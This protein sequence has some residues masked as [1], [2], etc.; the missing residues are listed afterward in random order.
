MDYI[1]SAEI[2]PDYQTTM[3]SQYNLLTFFGKLKEAAIN[4]CKFDMARTMAV[5]VE[6]PDESQGL[7]SLYCISAF[8][9]HP[10]VGGKLGA[11]LDTGAIAPASHHAENL[12]Y[13][14][15]SHTG[16][17]HQT[18]SWGRI[19]R[20]K[21]GGSSAACCGKLA[22]VME[23]YLKEYEYAKTNIKVFKKDGEVFLK[24]PHRFLGTQ[25]FVEHS[26]VR[27][28][29]NSSLI[30]TKGDV[31]TEGI[32]MTE[33]PHL[34][35]FKIH[36]DLLCA[37]RAKNKD[38]TD[39]PTPIGDDLTGDYFKFQWVSPDPVPDDITGRL[40]PLMH[41]IV[42][43]LDYHPMVTVANVQTQIEFNRF[44]DAIH[45]IPDVETKGIFGVSGL[46][47]DLYFEGRPYP[48]SNVYYPQYAFFKRDDQREGLIMGPSE[49]NKLLAAYPLAM[50]RVSIDRILECNDKGNKEIKF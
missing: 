43:S 45:A 23:P 24:I 34:V 42:S 28:C 1:N 41:K 10:F 48:Y 44:V 3:F 12:V 33:S 27:L 26:S 18:K 32:I 5:K 6:C 11:E 29:L 47:V 46:T 39:E 15:G 14:M 21:E 35:I 20:E 37:L 22:A 9:T 25:S 2:I 4:Y 8:G 49:I 36:P 30:K 40:H 38:I 7:K 17:D 50:E 16:Y 19:Y 13:V 31:Q